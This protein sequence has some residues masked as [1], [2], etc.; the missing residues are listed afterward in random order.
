MKDK[1]FELKIDNHTNY[2]HVD[3]STFHWGS[4]DMMLNYFES[5]P[6]NKKDIIT[7]LKNTIEKYKLVEK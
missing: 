3:W 2:H 6:Y 5:T 7:G 1:D 4:L